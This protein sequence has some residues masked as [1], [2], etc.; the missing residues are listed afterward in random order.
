MSLSNPVA[1][2]LTLGIILM[3]AE[4]IIPGGIVVFIGLGAVLT[5]VLWFLG[6]TTTWTSAL[7]FF[8]IATMVLVMAFRGVS[9]K[10][11]GGDSH[12]ANT[13]ENL[14]IYGKTAQVL[15]TIGPGEHVGRIEF[16]GTQWPALGDGQEIPSG[17]E[18][19]IVCHE[20][21]SLLVEPK[22]HVS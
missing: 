12:I 6:I 8:F 11:V 10:L 20:N 3:C 21:I 19:T 7:V 17:S 18:V 22:K 13:D 2:W 9:Q 5:G 14:D 4:L 15:E 1:I 16:Q